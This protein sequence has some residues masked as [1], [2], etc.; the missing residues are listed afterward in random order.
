MQCILEDKGEDLAKK[1][2][3]Q[4]LQRETTSSELESMANAAHR[5]FFIDILNQS[6]SEGSF[7]F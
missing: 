6:L 7:L 2:S 1:S 4:K 5:V 3:E